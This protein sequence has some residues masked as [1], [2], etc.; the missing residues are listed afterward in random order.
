MSG[1]APARLGVALGALLSHWR[2]RPG[3][4][5]TLMAGL[6][7]ATA[8]WSGVQA[9]NQQARDSYD[10][11]AAL[12]GGPGA[13]M[14]L[15]E[16]GGKIDQA[17]YVALRRAGWPVSP[18]LEG[19]VRLD[20]GESTRRVRVIG[21]EP[22]T[23]PIAA[24]QTLF[25]DSAFGGAAEA[26]GEPFDFVAFVTPPGLA[27]AAPE[28][29]A[30]LGLPPEGGVLRTTNGLET[31][32]LRPRQALAPSALV[33]DIGAAQRLLGAERA[34]TRLLLDAEAAGR[35]PPRETLDMVTSRLGAPPLRQVEPEE[36]GDLARLTDS[37]HLN[38]TAFGLL[39]FLV[40]LFIVHG[41][42]GLAFEQR[43]STIRTLRAIGVSGRLLSVAL[44][45][46]LVGAALIAGLI[47]VALG[48]LVAAALLP[49]VAATL[50]GLYG[51]AVGRE[52]ALDPSWWAAGV[53]MSVAG[54]LT[55]AA[56]SLVKT[57]RA[58]V[59]AAAQPAAWRAA[60]RRWTRG[61]AAA[62]LGLLA[63][64]AVFTLMGGGLLGAFAALAGL[65]LGAALLLPWLLD[66]ALTLGERIAA[67]R[68]GPPTASWFWADG[69][70]QLSALSLALMALLLA[71]SANIGVGAMVESFRTT[72]TAWLDKR[73][74]AEIYVSPN[75]LE[76][77]AEIISW[78]RSEE[79]AAAGVTA[80]LPSGRAETQASGWPAALVGVEDH[81]TYRQAWPFAAV[82]PD[83]WDAIASG[84]GVLV[85]EQLARRL[86]LWVGDVLPLTTAN[87]AW[88][89]RIA[90][91]YPDYGAPNGEITLSNTAL[92][93]RW[94]PP[95][96]VLTAARAAPERVEA[97]VAQIRSRFGLE[98]T[99]VLDQASLKR[100]S[101][102]VF[103]RTFAVTSALN[104]LTLAVAGVA[105][106][107]SLSALADMRL[108]QLAPLWAMGL[109]RR[110][111][112]RLELLKTLALA[113]FTAVL[114]IP[115]GLALAWGLVAVVNVEAFGWR[116]P[117]Y[118]FP[119]QWLEALALAALAALL[120]AAWP[121]RRLARTPP[122]R[123]L[124]VFAEER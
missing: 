27:Y 64:S 120:A 15:A 103:N 2:R 36:E 14:L 69:R 29:L 48:Y 18:V 43:L 20:L 117:L 4:L 123:L 46:E 66:A 37:F 78:L 99:R 12:F 11:A 96:R 59:L 84:D 113:L 76:Q 32:P 95:E 91:V 79:G 24:A 105:L 6:A 13:P 53:A 22:L 9:L 81:A 51:A 44:V 52:L 1:S 42:I 5:L 90:G 65:M 60:H 114:A 38:L 124:R 17:V 28:T 34:L 58:P 23:T 62:G 21:V 45:I 88:A 122:A 49:D 100:Y 92:T 3:Q 97:L 86:G 55:A 39:S 33:M 83:A 82:A 115:L 75:S 107:T 16:G 71:L 121:A 50:R 31:P 19:R 40:G 63:L 57:L 70:Q 74:A 101:N 77:A 30:E 26:E 109:T 93:A 35:V 8:L 68:G 85:S 73:L 102:R 111:L 116:L 110:R 87:G 80:V 25:G 7:L 89:P 72:F 106:L 112:A 10:R 67:R 94:G 41:A 118:L 98:E 54:A 61:Q 108:P 56:Q 119:L 104:A 47:G